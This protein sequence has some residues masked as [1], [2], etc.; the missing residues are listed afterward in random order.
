MRILK[1]LVAVSA[2]AAVASALAM[3]PAL[4]DPVNGHLKP[5]TPLPYDIVGVGSDTTQNMLDQLSVDYNAAHKTHNATHPYIYSWDATPPSDPTI[6]TPTLIKPKAGCSSKTVRPDGSSAGITD[7]TTTQK[8]KYKGKTYPCFDFSRSS[9]PRKATDPGKTSIVFVTLARDAVTYATSAVTNAPANLTTKQLTEIYS[10]TV[11]ATGG[12]PANNWADLGG[13]SGTIDPILPQS[14][15]GTLSFFLGAIG[16]TTPGSCVN[17]TTPE[18]NEGTAPVFSTDSANLIFPF[19]A[20][21]YIADKYHSPACKKKPGA[22][23]NDFGCN[24]TGKLILRSINGEAPTSGT[25]SKTVIDSKFPPT[26]KRFLYDVVPY[27]AGTANHIPA[28]LAGFFSKTGWF[29]SSARGSV[30]RDY[31]FLTTPLCG[32]TS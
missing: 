17:A 2:V 25:G 15:S 9:R 28:N 3:A 1:N 6:T 16:V 11:Q 4:A 30:I 27:A 13:K 31:G 29:C 18:E 23:Q 8:I 32:F 24:Q 10:C 19:S 21:A 5:V 20:G 7:L 14:G 22:G 12:H 26:F